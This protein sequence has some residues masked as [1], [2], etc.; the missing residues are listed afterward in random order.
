LVRQRD[1]AFGKY[2]WY[3]STFLREEGRLAALI[4]DT[5]GATR[6]Y[7]EYLTLCPNPEL[8]LQPEVQQV[9]AELARLRRAGPT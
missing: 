6:A 5:L 2:P 4:G 3:F 9:R 1:G 7:Q 8:Q